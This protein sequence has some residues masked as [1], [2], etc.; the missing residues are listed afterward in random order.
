MT[1]TIVTLA[2]IACL[3]V[4]AIGS[5]YAL[6]AAAAMRRLREPAGEVPVA[7]PGVSVLKPLAGA[8][9]G[10]ADDLRSFCDQAYRGPV[11]IVFGVR[12]PSDP[13]VAVV[14]RLIAD[15]PAC[16]LS[17]IV[18]ASVAASNPKIANLAGLEGAIRHDVVIASDADIAV[19]RDYLATTIAALETPGTGAVTLLYRG[20][21]RA[22]AWSRLASMGID[23]HFLPS[24]V[25]GTSLGLAHPCF[26]STIAL[27]RPLLAAIGGFRAFGE[28]LADD[29]AVGEAVR[30][31]G[32]AVSIPPMIVAHACYESRFAEVVRHELRWA[33]TVRAVSP[34]G[35]AG[36]I[37]THPL[38]FA[39]A[40]AALLGAPGAWAIAAAVASRLV[41]QAQVDHTLGVPG[42]RWWLGPVRDVLSFCIHVAGY[43]VDV[44]E[45]GRQRYRIRRDGTL[46]SAE[47]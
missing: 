14:E 7:W 28:I 11:Q 37:V 32:F 29:Y 22:N 3:L 10:L 21:A 31:R 39:V 17:L 18:H 6:A 26:G 12:D 9:P 4:A 16:D 15:R 41:L 13:A 43:F 45:W 5:L 36:S 33:R 34:A 42:R 2:G 40:A 46:S 1:D 25:V 44:V 38:P 23:Y 24:V 35:Y 30:A 47:P 19:P 8:P 27:R 20:V